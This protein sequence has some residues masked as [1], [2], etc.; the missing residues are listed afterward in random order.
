MRL[1]QKQ[2]KEKTE[3]ATGLGRIIIIII[4]IIIT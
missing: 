3:K 4:I 1:G 2:N